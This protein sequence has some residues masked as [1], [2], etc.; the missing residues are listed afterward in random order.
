MVIVNERQIGGG[1][2]KFC[3]RILCAIILKLLLKIL[4]TPLVLKE[5]THLK[6]TSSMLYY[7]YGMPN[8]TDTNYIASSRRPQ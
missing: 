7:H 6:L 1:R 3:R 4:V 5:H 8:Q 2:K